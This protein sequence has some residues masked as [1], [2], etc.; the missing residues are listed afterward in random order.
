MA[1][2]GAPLGSSRQARPRPARADATVRP[3]G[4]PRGKRLM[5]HPPEYGQVHDQEYAAL[6]LRVGLEVHQQL[7]T[8]KKLFCHCPAGRY[9]NRYDAEILRHMRPTL[10]ELG[11]YDGTAL[12]EFKTR[13]EIYYRLSRE[14]VCTYEMDDAPPFEINEQ[15]VDIAIEV[16]L[17]L[18]VQMIDELHIARKQYLD[19][20]IP[21][22]FQRT[23]ILG[24]NGWLAY[25]G[26]LGGPAVHPDR[27]IGIRQLALEEDSCREVADVGHRRTYIADRL[28]MPLIEVVTEPQM[29]TPREAAEVGQHIRYLTRATGKMRRGIGSCRQ[30]V[31]VSIRGGT[32]IEIKGVPRV[33]LIPRLVHCEAYRQKA[34]LG[35]RDEL[36][37][38]GVRREDWP[39]YTRDVTD[40]LRSTRFGVL[41]AALG[42]GRRVQAVRLPRFGGLLD[43]PTQPHTVMLQEFADRVRVIACLQGEP[44]LICSDVPAHTLPPGEW[45]KVL[46]TTGAEA[47]DAVMLVWGDAEDLTTAVEEI[48]IRALDAMEGVPQETR[49]AFA[50]GANGFERI[51]PGPDRMYPDTDLPPKAIPRARIDAVRLHLPEPPTDKMVRYAALGL[52]GE[53][54]AALVRSGTAEIFDAVRRRVP[55]APPA[56]LA[57]TLTC[58][59]P[60]A[61]RRGSDVRRLDAGVLAELFGLAVREGWTREAVYDAVEG[62]LGSTSPPGPTEAPPTAPGRIDA[63]ALPA[64]V[65]SLLREINPAPRPR[66]RRPQPGGGDH[67]RGRL[68]RVC[69]GHVMRRLR[70]RAHGREVGEL[71]ARHLAGLDLP[72]GAP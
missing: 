8:E 71:I 21:T 45:R 60:D 56:L 6:G 22:G 52:S 64:A 72:A 40:V 16:A 38:R 32:R 43:R 65:Q 62:V 46:R 17:L 29:H 54:S 18:Q 68:Q 57:Y 27:R 30:D 3:Y 58:H 14:T 1:G 19:G 33:P 4:E 50:D 67:L 59:L 55:D 39:M 11:E 37:T 7:L 28:G 47:T 5:I 41:A 36:G 44:N 24:V 10:S 69:M 42:A 23:T 25:P 12:M 53:L 48:R 26:P 31:N 35:V 66:S 13:K 15:A 61:R 34:L 9:A 20:S 49:Q 2:A 63:E 51:L 70:G